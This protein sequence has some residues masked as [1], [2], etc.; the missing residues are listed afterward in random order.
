MED[1]IVYENENTA[2][3]VIEGLSLNTAQASIRKIE[4]FQKLIQSQFKKD[5]DYGVIPGTGKPTLLKP[6]AEKLVILLGLSVRFE[7]LDSTRDFEE[8]FF[9]Y[10]VR[11]V[12]FKNGTLITEGFG[13]CN[14]KEKRYRNQ[15]AFTLDNTIL[16]MAEKRA[17]VDGALHVGALSNLFTQDIEEMESFNQRERIENLDLE[18]AKKLKVT[19]GVKHKGETLGEIIKSDRGYIKWL[20]TNAYDDTM[21]AGAA[22]LLES[23]SQEKVSEKVSDNDKGKA[24]ASEAEAKEEVPEPEYEPW[25]NDSEDMPF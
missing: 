22:L 6:G 24:S 11:C 17:L 25:V 15:D 9:Q 19:F 7:L 21:K 16:K 4:E 23:S 20:R 2:L 8:G 3:S 5:V 10:Q 13:S 1:N 14:S 18:S 12:L